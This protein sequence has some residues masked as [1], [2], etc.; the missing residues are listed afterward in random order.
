MKPSS[1]LLVSVLMVSTP[2][3]AADW[4]APPFETRAS[5]PPPVRYPV[6]EGQVSVVDGRTLWYPQAS[7]TVRLSGID[8]CELPQWA[9]KAEASKPADDAAL[10]PLPCGALAKAWLTR[11][12]RGAVVR[13]KGVSYDTQGTLGARCSVQGHD[14]GLE[15]LR[16]GWARTTEPASGSYAQAQRIA[17]A[18]HYGLW[19]SLV[20]DMNEW[21]RKAIDRTSARRPLADMHL[22]AER[23][24]EISPPFADARRLPRR[25][26]R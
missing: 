17:M 24:S 10:I 20:L 9:F 23:E 26:D 2:A 19:S 6:I 12:A 18:S 4:L 11:A 8:T 15:M 16:V 22:L 5:A 7:T 21:R 1:T 14:L 3:I 13:C 25:T